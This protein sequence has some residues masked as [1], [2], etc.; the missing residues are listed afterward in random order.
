MEK[1]RASNL[2]YSAFIVFEALPSSIKSILDIDYFHCSLSINIQIMFALYS[3]Y[4]NSKLYL[5]AFKL[6][7]PFRHNSIQKILIKRSKKSCAIKVGQ[8]TLED[9]AKPKS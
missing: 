7:I 2:A 8:F 9:N 4:S 3:V 6:L 1:P 5:Y